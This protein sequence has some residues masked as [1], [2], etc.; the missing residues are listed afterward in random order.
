MYCSRGHKDLAH[1]L[2]LIR[3]NGRSLR[4]FFSVDFTLNGFVPTKEA[5]I[6]QKR[7]QETIDEQYNVRALWHEQSTY[8]N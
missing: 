1:S 3:Y 8:P 7:K 2:R 5:E 4:G 6:V